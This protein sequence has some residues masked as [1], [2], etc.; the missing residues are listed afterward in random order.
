MTI[1]RRTLIKTGAAL[2]ASALGAPAFS[3]P[4]AKVSETTKTRLA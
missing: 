2:A 3:Q 1:D 4:R